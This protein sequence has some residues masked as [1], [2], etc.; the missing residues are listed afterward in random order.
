M[1]EASKNV[2]LEINAQKKKYMM[3]EVIRSQDRTRI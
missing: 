3:S 2:G 1:V